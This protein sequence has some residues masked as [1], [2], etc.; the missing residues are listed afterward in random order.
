[1]SIV[2]RPPQR[3]CLIC[4]NKL[5]KTMIRISIGCCRCVAL[6]S[7]IS[8]GCTFVLMMQSMQCNT[9]TAASGRFCTGM[10]SF[11]PLTVTYVATVWHC[12]ESTSLWEI[13]KTN[14][15][16]PS[17][18]PPVSGRSLYQW[19]RKW[20]PE[21]VSNCSS[22][23]GRINQEI[24]KITKND[25]ETRQVQWKHHVVIYCWLV[26]QCVQWVVKLR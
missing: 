4:G 19:W 16:F 10:Y 25:T 7:V 24:F 2:C 13:P 18:A 23:F 15:L 5:S 12:S 3:V 17:H 11:L 21:N 8:F 22:K 9:H 6:T 26:F 20:N 14:I 1:M